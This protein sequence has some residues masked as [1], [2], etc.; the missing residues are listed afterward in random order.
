[1]LKDSSVKA[2]AKMLAP[3][4]C[5]QVMNDDRSLLAELLME[6]VETYI[7]N[8]IGKLNDDLKYDLG[9]TILEQIRLVVA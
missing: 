5:E 7:D 4:I 3:E 6:Y 2:M 8:N 9:V 1:M